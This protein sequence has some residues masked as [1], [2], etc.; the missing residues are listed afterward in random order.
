MNSRDISESDK[1]A[2]LGA[3]RGLGWATYQSLIK[4]NPSAQYFLS[5]RKIQQRI[6][7]VT[8]L[9]QLCVQDFSKDE[10]DSDFLNKL[11]CGNAFFKPNLKSSQIKI[12]PITIQYQG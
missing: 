10:L 7:D 11:N 12:V 2:I 4:L 9:T 6:D 8:S 3:S 1:V 5:S